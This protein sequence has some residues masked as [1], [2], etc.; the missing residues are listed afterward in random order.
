MRYPV[1]AMLGIILSESALADDAERAKS[2]VASV[3][4]ACHGMDGNSTVPNFPKLAGRHPE[5]LVREM[6]EF[7]SG[8]AAP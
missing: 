2:I 8:L 4:S 1:A 5:Y 6:K 7:I 3:C